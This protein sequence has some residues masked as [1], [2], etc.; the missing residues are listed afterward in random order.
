MLLLRF[1]YAFFHLE[2]CICLTCTG[3]FSSLIPFLTVYK[4]PFMTVF[5][6]CNSLWL[7]RRIPIFVLSLQVHNGT[8]FPYF[9]LPPF[10]KSSR[11][12]SLWLVVAKTSPPV[13]VSP[14]SPPSFFCAP[15]PSFSF[16]CLQPLLEFWLFGSKTPFSGQSFA[17]ASRV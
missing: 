15:C 17:M 2:F 12:L 16:L 4:G 9:F 1:L 10:S 8:C 3:V 7:F 13:L 5:F 6:F 11:V 14:P